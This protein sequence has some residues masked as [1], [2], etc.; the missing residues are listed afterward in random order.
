MR[1]KER[2]N[3]ERIPLVKGNADREIAL[4]KEIP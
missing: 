4:L 3:F 2:V 1:K